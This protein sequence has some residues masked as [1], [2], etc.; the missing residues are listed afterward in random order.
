[1]CIVVMKNPMLCRNVAFSTCSYQFDCNS[2]DSFRDGV[3]RVGE[4]VV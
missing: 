3:E 1:M 4:G 2:A